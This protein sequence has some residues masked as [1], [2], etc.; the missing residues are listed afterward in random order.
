MSTS[1][2][3][4]QQL[5]VQAT[6]TLFSQRDD[7]FTWSNDEAA[8]TAALETCYEY[9]A[10]PDPLCFYSDVRAV[11]DGGTERRHL[12]Y[13]IYSSD[14]AKAI[15]PEHGLYSIDHTLYTPAAELRRKR[16]GNQDTVRSDGD[17]WATVRWQRLSGIAH[18]DVHVDGRFQLSDHKTSEPWLTAQIGYFELH[19]F[20]YSERTHARLAERIKSLVV[21]EDG[22]P[23]T[24]KAV[25][26]AECTAIVAQFLCHKCLH[27][28]FATDPLFPSLEDVGNR[29]INWLLETQVTNGSW[30]N[31]F[32]LTSHS[33]R[34]LLERAQESDAVFSAVTNAVTYL[35]SG[36]VRDGWNQLRTYEQIEVLLALLRVARTERFS[37]HYGR[38]TFADR[39]RQPRTF[40]SYAGCDSGFAKTVAKS[41]E[42]QGVPVWFAE[43]DI[44]YG[45][46]IV[47]EIQTGLETT[48]TFLII[49]TP[50]SVSRPWVR[51]ELS[52]VF[53]SVLSK[54]RRLIIPLMHKKCDPPV[55]LRSHK[56]I[57][58]T[59]AERFDETI[60]DLA[61][62][63]RQSPQRRK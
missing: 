34:A 47:E 6:R 12:R 63:L 44:D 5:L 32:H 55:F 26:K 20:F 14:V 2:H 4:L 45:D 30:D 62:R 33:I 35:M 23:W 19:D 61:R 15:E 59:T 42:D 40:I 24:S 58:F 52:A 60:A 11:R 21:A 43:W 9:L 57:D 48:D 16:L 53:N 49:L 8:T 28:A 50:E 3:T 1:E 39:F 54:D 29:A 7:D 38:V 31:S 36:A 41:L 25:S 46:D 51:K 37:L 56:W 10:G 18:P 13:D 22:P 17:A 27:H